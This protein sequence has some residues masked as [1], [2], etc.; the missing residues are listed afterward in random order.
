MGV[1]ECEAVTVEDRSWS[2][3][4]LWSIEGAGRLPVSRIDAKRR[5]RWV[6]GNGQRELVEALDGQRPPSGGT[7]RVHGKPY[8]ARRDEM[9]DARFYC[10]PEEPLR[11]ACIA[12]MSVAENLVMRDFDRPPFAFGGWWL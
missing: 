5:S 6:S 3:V 10:L 2:L 1:E 4:T 12:G 8:H 9:H 11:N 7:V